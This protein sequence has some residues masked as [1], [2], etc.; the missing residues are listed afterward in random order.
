MFTL[1]K[2]LF[3]RK[4][5][6]ASPEERRS[7]Y[8]TLCSV[9][10]IFLNV[11]LFAGKYL[12]GVFS[13]SIAVMAD[14]FNNLGDAASSLITLIGFR[15]A[16]QKPDSKHPFGHGRM[17]Y[18]SGLAVSVL[19]VV[20]GVELL[21]SSAA[22]I[23]IPTPV[24]VSNLTVGILVAAIVVKGY[25]FFY[26]HRVGTQ[27]DSSGMK[28]AAADSISDTVATASVLLATLAQRF[29]G[30]Q[31]DGWMGA[32]VAL[33][34]IYTGVR[35]VW[36]TVQPLLGQMPDPALVKEIETMVLSYKEVQ[37]IHDLVIHDYG[38]GRRMISLHAEVDGAADVFVT[39][40]AIDLI[41]RR[42]CDELGCQAVIHMDPI[43]AND[44]TV[45]TLRHT[46]ETALRQLHPAVT[47]HD[48]RTVSGPTHTNVIFD[49]VVPYDLKDEDSVLVKQAQA[50]ISALD[51]RLFA[52]IQ[53]DRAYTE[54]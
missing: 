2:K 6:S 33:F 7:L 16:G 18:L 41:E 24:E 45:Q 51:D 28:A 37:G 36:E 35:S 23:M 12:A 11:C 4:A 47:V 14:A 39:H 15:L 34:V 13:G 3:S 52:V 27:L 5:A 49:M 42:L 31:I 29:F 8:G 9:L 19:I 32:L 30:W 17:E 20:V 1:L 54:G 22:K 38:P 25:M 21:S 53:V 10:G 40:D 26:N 50:L 44:E 46:V 48:F 43:A